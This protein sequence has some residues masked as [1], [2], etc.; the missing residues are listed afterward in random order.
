MVVGPRFMP[1]RPVEGPNG[2]GWHPD[3]TRVPDASRISPPYVGK[4]TRNGHDISIEVTAEAGFPITDYRAVTH[5]VAAKTLPDGSLRLALAEQ[6]SIPNRDF[7]LRY[8]AG[9]DEP[10]AILQTSA[11][12]G[13]EGYFSLAV[14]PPMLDVES[15]VGRREIIFVVDVSG[16]MAGL[17][18]SLCRDAMRSALARL[19]PVDTF[20]IVTFA[21]ESMRA[22]EAPRPANRQNV[23]EALR[24]VDG[25]RAGGGTQM[26]NA[27]DAA[28]GTN[29]EKGRSRYVFFMTDGY[30]G[31]DD[32]IV[33]RSKDFVR[34]LE[35]RGQ[36][37]RVFGFG[38]GS[39]VNRHLIDGLSRAGNGIAVYASSREHPDRAVNRFYYYIDRAVLSNLRVNWANFHVEE[40]EPPEMPDLFASHAIILHG[41]YRGA[42]GNMTLRADAGGET[43][44]IPIRVAKA[45]TTGN[46]TVVFGTLW[47]RSKVQH[48]EEALLGRDQPDPREA[49]VKL[50]LEFN[51][52]TR[53]TS[54]IAI[55]T[56]RKVG[57]GTPGLVVQPNERPE[58]VDLA[59]A[60][61]REDEGLGQEM[62][63][64]AE[65]LESAA[66]MREQVYAVSRVTP[67]RGCGCRVAERGGDSAASG[68]VIAGLAMLWR[69]KRRRRKAGT[70]QI[71]HSRR[72]DADTASVPC[73]FT[74]SSTPS[75]AR[76]RCSSL[77]SRH[78]A[79][80][81]RR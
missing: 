8:R 32:E 62:A 52:V 10:R 80:H 81:G 59:M 3:T 40:L 5:A 20:N 56:S 74:Y 26:V 46:P 21:G 30:V 39:S 43:V 4:G 42:P 2:T 37:A 48:L 77:S 15:L 45:V 18:L 75:S 67:K 60:G 76:P 58:G 31:N 53:Y 12:N 27:I 28:L 23:A 35:E 63:S 22:F 55:D 68:A 50:G 36:R 33:G 54:L 19:R 72:R 66:P 24:I 34:A 79:E 16:S 49:I 17:P 25:L 51:L 41:R 11:K 73:T 7:I 47:A 14:Y 1:G 64:Y 57:N 44:E 65:S 78:R 29:V 70:P 6:D 69:R 38:V 13:E 61:Y 9:A 71:L